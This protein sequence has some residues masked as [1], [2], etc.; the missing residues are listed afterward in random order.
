MT[1]PQVE[2]RKQ[3]KQEQDGTVSA[4]FT[5]LCPKCGHSF[6]VFVN[7]YPSMFRLSEDINNWAT[8]KGFPSPSDYDDNI[9]ILSRLMLAVSELG[10]AAEAMRKIPVDEANFREE[11]ADCIIR[12]FHLCGALGIDI[13]VEIA[14][15]MEVNRG[16]PFRHGKST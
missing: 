15:K 12:L 9:M 2:P 7:T 5:P 16:R 8:E 14:A 3:L 4:S 11:V 1:D 10:E 13:D 6:S